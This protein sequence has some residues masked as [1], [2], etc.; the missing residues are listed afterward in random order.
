VLEEAKLL[1]VLG[2]LQRRVGKGVEGIEDGAPI[3][4]HAHVLPVHDVARLVTIEGNGQPGEVEG[5]AVHVGHHL[6]RGLRLCTSS[7]VARILRVVTWTSGLL[8][9]W[10]DERLDVSGGHERL[11]SWMLT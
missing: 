4:V 7:G 2:A 11:V 10:P 1:E 9:E 8:E 5:I 6:V 3:G